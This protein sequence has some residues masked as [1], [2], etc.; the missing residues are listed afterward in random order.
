M[1]SFIVAKTIPTTCLRCLITRIQHYG[2]V[3]STSS[4]S[5]NQ[6]DLSNRDRSS[7]R[8]PGTYFIRKDVQE[9]LTAL[10]G[11][12]LTK[13]F[14]IKN[15]KNFDRIVY[16][17]LT[18]KQLKEEQDQTRERSREKLQMPPVLSEAVENIE[19]LEK[20]KMLEGFSSSKHLFIDISLGIPMRDRMIVAREV[21]GT[22]RTASLDEQRR[23]RQIYF[24][25]QGRE[26][27]M[28]KMFEEKHLDLI[29]E[30]GDYE[31]VLDRACAQ[32]EPDDREYIHVTHTTYEH[33]EK[34][35]SYHL[36]HST[37]HFGPLAFYFVWYKKIDRLLNDIIRRN[38][39]NDAVA[40]LQL[41]AIIHPESKVA[42]YDF[43]QNQP[44]DLI[45]YFI[46]DE[47]RI[48]AL[49]EEALRQHDQNQ[50]VQAAKQ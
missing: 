31:F 44:F 30:R 21:D 37:R 40:L 36:L 35:N 9:L 22:L 6:D 33:I 13:I 8:D 20:D 29:L 19:I 5:S 18:D 46:E 38:S 11:F 32:F 1:F 2:T 27:I 48:P 49:I 4:E 3:N 26:L 34:T 39:I 45:Q 7:D 23:M 12:D 41:Y 24:P 16:K 17:Y 28:P 43:A 14:R 15:N 25:I 42:E 50:T 10:T 47:A